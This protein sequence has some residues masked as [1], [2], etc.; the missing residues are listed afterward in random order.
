VSQGASTNHS[1]TS[2]PV[3]LEH[4]GRQSGNPPYL[5]AEQNET[6]LINH[7]ASHVVR[8]PTGA[9][10]SLRSLYLLYF[11][12][13]TLYSLAALSGGYSR[14]FHSLLP[15]AEPAL[16]QQH[17]APQRTVTARPE[18]RLEQLCL[19]LQPLLRTAGFSCY[20]LCCHSSFSWGRR[21]GKTQEYTG[22]ES[23][24]FVE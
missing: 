24:V 5:D 23:R 10:Q 4:S 12:K 2:H 14:H 13:E 8:G 7:Q 21:Q 17:R 16:Q 3:P 22:S 18:R 20:R 9:K 19:V 11:P 6:C 1:F 15:A